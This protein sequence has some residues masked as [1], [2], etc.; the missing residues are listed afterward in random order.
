MTSALKRSGSTTRWRKI[1]DEV[2]ARDGW[3][4]QRCG[5]DS[6]LEVDHITERQ[7]GGD[8]QL[9]NLQTLCRNCHK[10]KRGVFFER[11]RTPPTPPVLLSPQK[12]Q[13][14][15]HRTGSSLIRTESVS[16]E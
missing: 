10:H 14:G 9:E 8:D 2:L 12:G 11:D 16:H 3:M 1:R 15:H 13:I 6:N 4:C 5:E 7:H